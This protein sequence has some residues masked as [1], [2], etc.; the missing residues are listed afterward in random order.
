MPSRLGP[1]ILAL[2]LLAAG[3]GI[4]AAWRAAAGGDDRPL[5]PLTVELPD[6]DPALADRG[7]DG[8]GGRGPADA[9]GP[10]APD[11]SGGVATPS[12][13]PEGRAMLALDR[14][15]GS[16]PLVWVRSGRRV[17]V[18]TEPGGGTLVERAGRR[19]EFGSTTVFGVVRRSG[20]WAA[21]TTPALPNERLGW[22]EL[23]PR[24]LRAGWTRISI[25]VDLSQRR[26]T[27][28]AGG[29]AV[30]SFAVTVGMPGADTPTGRY[31][32]TDTFRGGLNTAYG[33]CAVA[34][35]A[36]QPNLP[37]GWLGGRRIAIHGTSGPLGVAASHGCVRAADA[38]VSRLVDRVP[39]GAPVFIRI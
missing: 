11:R 27:L 4:V 19:T 22:V 6:P 34:L 14:P 25:A 15:P 18:R 8:R 5:A 10:A 17:E 39:L 20:R 9:G 16:Y 38:E 1:L 30:R 29:E 13:E 37:S 31:S 23:D 33:C 24:L 3:L 7:D 21:V 2:A 35:S 28:L 26:A 32:V 36:T 12:G